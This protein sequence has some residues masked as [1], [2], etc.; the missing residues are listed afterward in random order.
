MPNTE[1]KRE[2]Y[3][4]WRWPFVVILPPII[5]IVG[6]VLFHLLQW[7][8]VKMTGGPSEGSWIFL[9]IMPLFAA[10]A[11]GWLY[12]WV[13]VLVA[14]SAKFAAAAVMIIIFVVF[15][16][17]ASFVA[18]TGEEYSALQAISVA[19]MSVSAFLG[20]I[21]ALFQVHTSDEWQ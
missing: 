7:F 18:I 5:A 16:I 19:L 12:A 14:P 3:H 11:F 4:W 2:K 13:A 20:A 17:F 15:S 6:S 10:A 1:L 21:Y 8:S 9:Y